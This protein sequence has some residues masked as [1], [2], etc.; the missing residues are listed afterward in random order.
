M[1]NEIINGLMLLIVGV[2]SYVY[3]TGYEKRKD[4]RELKASHK[5]QPKAY[6]L[7][8]KNNNHAKR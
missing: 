4:R 2:L 6:F 1:E 7:N 8:S 5:K 3:G